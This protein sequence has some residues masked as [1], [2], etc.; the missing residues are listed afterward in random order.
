[1]SCSETWLFD[2]P[3]EFKTFVLSQFDEE[4]AIQTRFKRLCILEQ[5]QNNLLKLEII[6]KRE[7]ILMLS[8]KLFVKEWVA[9]RFRPIPERE[10]EFN[11]GI[12]RM[13]FE[14]ELDEMLD[15]QRV[16]YERR[17]KDQEFELDMKFAE[18][19]TYA[20][21]A[22]DKF[23]QELCEVKAPYDE[24]NFEVGRLQGELNA[25]IESGR[26]KRA[27]QALEL[28]THFDVK[29]VAALAAADVAADMNHAAELAIVEA[30]HQEKY[31]AERRQFEGRLVADLT[32][33]NNLK[34]KYNNLK[35]Y[36]N[37]R[38]QPFSADCLESL[39]RRFD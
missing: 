17:M 18:A 29:L 4:A 37:R 39:P 34:H 27:T 23:S 1:M 32:N 6:D 25:A 14:M 20:N 16:K 10:D 30:A 31:S 21:V 12:L 15:D 11:K 9:D 22:C 38:L 36:C 8:N 28:A 24:K 19:L 26:V 5:S 3:E 35:E 13:Q 33:Y 2:K 7:E